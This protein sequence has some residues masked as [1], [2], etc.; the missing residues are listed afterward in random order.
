MMVLTVGEQDC[1]AFGRVGKEGMK[2]SAERIDLGFWEGRNSAIGK[3][4]SLLLAGSGLGAE[5]EEFF[6]LVKDDEQALVLIK[7]PCSATQ[8][9]ERRESF[10]IGRLIFP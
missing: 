5:Q 10:I 9:I 2:A 1:Y 6:E 3:S 7:L 8:G 4:R